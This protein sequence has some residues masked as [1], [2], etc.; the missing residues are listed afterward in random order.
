MQAESCFPASRG[1]D[2]ACGAGERS[3]KAV[4]M[5]LKRF[6]PGIC[7]LGNG[8]PVSGH[9][10]VA[11]R[12]QSMCGH[13]ASFPPWK[14]VGGDVQEPQKEEAGIGGHLAHPIHGTS[15]VCE[16]PSS[17]FADFR[18]L[19]HARRF[20][21]KFWCPCSR[22]GSQIGSQVPRLTHSHWKISVPRPS[23]SS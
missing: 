11:R 12:S 4:P 1:C 7:P 19:C 13:G 17:E 23:G 20:L 16:A 5:I 22:Q 8:H 2:S 15:S 18:A 10:Q 14:K 3:G 6:P 9:T 21:S